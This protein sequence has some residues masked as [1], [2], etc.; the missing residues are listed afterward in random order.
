M[1]ILERKIDSTIDEKMISLVE[2]RRKY[3]KIKITPIS[4]DEELREYARTDEEFRKI[5]EEYEKMQR[6]YDYIR[7]RKYQGKL[8][9]KQ[10]QR[11]KEGEIGGVFGYSTRIEELAKRYGIIEKDID[12]LLT[13]F[14]TLDNFY[15][16]HN[17]GKIEDKKDRKLEER[18]IRNVVDIDDNSN[19]GYDN[20][21]RDILR[22]KTSE[23]GVFFYSS[24]GLQ[25]ALEEIGE[26]AKYV[27]ESIYGLKEG[28]T[29]KTLENV[30]RELGIT[31]GGVSPIKIKA[32]RRLRNPKN[33]ITL[34]LEGDEY[35]TD[36]ERQLI[37][38][39]KKKYSITKW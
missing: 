22:I 32:L 39:I 18:I 37:E 9:E 17:T 10:M 28:K 24:K 1:G 19:I 35:L 13:K 26:R 6:Y 15:E 27:I 33:K 12:Y 3:P 23:K 25:K 11:G 5:Q 2:W 8:N 16:M 36:K 14:G 4:T 7:Y 20:L 21:Y 31:A 38:K 34:E 29:P 30:G